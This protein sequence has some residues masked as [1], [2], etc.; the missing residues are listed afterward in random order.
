MTG[1]ANH[2][3]ANLR[4]FEQRGGVRCPNFIA[5]RAG[6]PVVPGTCCAPAYTDAALAS[7]LPDATFAL[8]FGAKNKVAEQRIEVAAKRNAA[9]E[10]ARLQAEL[11][12]RDDDQQ[13]AQVRTQADTDMETVMDADN[14]LVLVCPRGTF[15]AQ[16]AR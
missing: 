11:A 8:Y 4:R 3:D 7:R 2:E 12:K 16:G 6:Q 14:W 10:V 15:T 13:A 5:P 1:V 9:A